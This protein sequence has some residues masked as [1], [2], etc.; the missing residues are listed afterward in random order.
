MNSIYL[1]EDDPDIVSL[2]KRHLERGG[3]HSVSTFANGAAFLAACQ[4]RVPDLVILDLSLP[5]TDGL[6]LCREL[7][8][9][10][11][12]SAVPTLLVR[13]RAGERDRVT[14]LDLG[15]DDYLTKPFSLQE[16]AAR[17]RA[18]QR[19][20]Q[21]ERGTAGEAYEDARLEIDR[22]RHKVTF[23]GKDVHLTKRELDLL[24]YLISLGG[25]VAT[26]EQIVEVVWGPSS[27]V[28]TRIVDVHVR[29]LRRKLRDDVIDTLIGSGYRFKRRQ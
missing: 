27:D 8:A 16:L 1:V 3:D 24:W 9:W 21:R 11:T 18:L 15:A 4:E 5:D 13:A 28:D 2:I 12:T 22:A 14:G 19:R 20:V 25:R 7:R 6:T 10:D 23:E 17:V 26:R 29:S